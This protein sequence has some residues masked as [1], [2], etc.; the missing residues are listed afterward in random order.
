MKNSVTE[1]SAI[2]ALKLKLLGGFELRLTGGEVANLPGQKDRALLA[3]LA[4]GPAASYSRERLAGLLWSERSD[5]QARD[6]LKHALMQ[7]RRNLNLAGRSV[8]HTDRQSIALDRA[9][10]SIDVLEFES[11]VRDNTRRSLAETTALYRGDLLDGIVVRDRAFE[12]WLLVERQR[13]RQ[14]FE[15]VLANLMS[16]ALTAGDPDGAAQAA[17][18][19]L[20]L[21][22]LSEAAYRTLMQVHCEQAQSAQAVKLYG[23]LRARLQRELGVLPEPSTAE[24]YDRIRRR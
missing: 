4:I 24:L 15:R 11:L 16:K 19:L 7:L 20:E 17:R 2:A 3:F 1:P 8:L 23:G 6:S 13:L 12:D 22:P 14:L 5:R 9:A 21:D 18:R 10:I